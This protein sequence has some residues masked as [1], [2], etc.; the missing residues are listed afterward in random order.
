MPLEGSVFCTTT[1]ALMI[2]AGE[3]SG[4]LCHDD[5]STYHCVLALEHVEVTVDNPAILQVPPL[6]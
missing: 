2:P 4:V 1:R 3:G 6:R 5:D